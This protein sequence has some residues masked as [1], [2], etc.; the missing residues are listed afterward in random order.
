MSH[1]P[2]DILSALATLA[3]LLYLPGLVL[4]PRASTALPATFAR[5]LTRHFPA[6]ATPLKGVDNAFKPWKKK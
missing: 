5:V 6:L 3:L 2:L 1:S 4:I